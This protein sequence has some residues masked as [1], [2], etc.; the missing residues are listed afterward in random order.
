MN[1]IRILIE[2]KLK[3]PIGVNVNGPSL[4]FSVV[5]VPVP[6]MVKLGGLHQKG[7][8]AGRAKPVPHQTSGRLVI[9]WVTPD[10]SS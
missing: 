10:G 6:S 9:Q 1:S 8:P 2:M 5:L 3:L 7:Y 4:W